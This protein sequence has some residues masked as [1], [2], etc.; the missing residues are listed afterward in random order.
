MTIVKLIRETERADQENQRCSSI[1][2][3]YCGMRTR[4]DK[5]FGAP[6][7]SD[8]QELGRAAGLD[9]A[10]DYAIAEHARLQRELLDKS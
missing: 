9:G 8:A 4:L 5:A 2:K 3:T 1:T 6:K 10:V 7:G